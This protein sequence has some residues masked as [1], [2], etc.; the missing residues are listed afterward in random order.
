MIDM[1]NRLFYYEICP[2][3]DRQF[4]V[5]IIVRPLLI[6]CANQALK[7]ILDEDPSNENHV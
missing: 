1:L 3:Q 4:G 2:K 6:I 7:K 5:D